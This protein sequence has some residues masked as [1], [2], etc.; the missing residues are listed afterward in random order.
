MAD[1]D[2]HDELVELLVPYS[3]GELDAATTARIERALDDD[4]TLR[5]EL[6]AIEETGARLLATLP[7]HAAPEALKGRVMDAVGAASSRR[8]DADATSPAHAAPAHRPRSWQWRGF[9]LPA[10]SGVLAVACTVLALLVVDLR[11]DLD[12]ARSRLERSDAGQ[13]P[14]VRAGDAREVETSDGLANASGSLRAVGDDEYL[15]VIENLP[16][17]DPGTS[18]QVWT[19]DAEGTIRNV[20]QWTSGDRIQ[21][22]VIDQADIT[23]VMI[24]HERSTEPVPAPTSAPIASVRV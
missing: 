20:A 16:R 19:A 13:A 5:H 11:R 17:P 22:L 6:D 9:A 18:W 1:A 2:R 14:F 4:P 7:R 23:Q 21:L 15:L 24:S 8:V 3:L 10:A 12:D